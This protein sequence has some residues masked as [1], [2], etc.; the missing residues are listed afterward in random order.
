MLIDN[1]KGKLV[2]LVVSSQSGAGISNGGMTR[3]STISSV[4]TIIGKLKDYDE[5]YIEL[6][7]NQM[8]S[9]TLLGNSPM[10]GDKGTDFVKIDNCESM[11]INKSKIITIM[12]INE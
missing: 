8:A 6:E 1:Y 11:L 2:K 5:E 7:K 9:A 10:I 12:L 4:I 3:R